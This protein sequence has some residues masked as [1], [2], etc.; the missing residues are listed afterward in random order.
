MITPWWSGSVR[1]FRRL[2]KYGVHIG[3]IDIPY[4]L[5]HESGYPVVENPHAD[6]ATSRDRSCPNPVFRAS[7]YLPGNHGFRWR[8]GGLKKDGNSSTSWN[9]LVD[10]PIH[11]CRRGYLAAGEHENLSLAR[12]SLTCFYPFWVHRKELSFTMAF[13]CFFE[14][15]SATRECSI[16]T[17]GSCGSVKIQGCKKF[18]ANVNL[19]RKWRKPS[20]I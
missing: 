9:S 1:G 14:V 2:G 12:L 19:L 15:E 18:S 4:A 8:C 5:F 7:F 6:A 17:H 11:I 10:V 3:M 16:K 20:F 13:P